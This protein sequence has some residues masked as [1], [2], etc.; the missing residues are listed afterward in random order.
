MSC[1]IHDWSPGFLASGIIASATREDPALA[2]PARVTTSYTE[3]CGT[4]LWGRLTHVL[5]QETSGWEGHTS[6]LVRCL[7][8]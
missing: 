1:A 3:V 7:P 2:F 6:W 5:G 8:E 4:S